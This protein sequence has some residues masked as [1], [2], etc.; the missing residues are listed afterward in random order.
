M[1][2]AFHWSIQGLF[3]PWGEKG[4]CLRAEVPKER[5]RFEIAITNT[6][7]VQ[8][9]ENF[10]SGRQIWK[11][12]LQPY[13]LIVIVVRIIHVHST[14]PRYATMRDFSRWW[15]NVFN[16][17]K[18]LGI[19]RNYIISYRYILCLQLSRLFQNIYK[20]PDVYVCC[21]YV[22]TNTNTG[23]LLYENRYSQTKQTGVTHNVSKYDFTCKIFAGSC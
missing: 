23:V 21:W 6:P 20:S 2:L 9:L 17:P 13:I 19:R 22:V 16:V 12:S 18:Q 3:I 15:F 14:C 4:G 1:R 7:E 8:V 5:E 10:A 11:K